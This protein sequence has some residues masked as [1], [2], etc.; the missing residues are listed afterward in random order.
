VKKM[1]SLALTLIIVAAFMVPVVA[2]AQTYQSGGAPPTAPISQPLV[3]E[4]TIAVKMVE[5]FKLGA[6]TDEVEAENL[7]V[8]AGIAPRN[9]WIADY[10]VTP[11]IA[12]EL[13][14]AVSDAADSG[15]LAM[16]K[17][18]AVLAFD[19]ILSE[20]NLAVKPDTSGQAAEEQAAAYPDN[21]VIDDYYYDEGPPVV[22]Y[23]APPPYYAHLYSWVPYPFWWWNFSFPGFFVL[24]DFHRP[25]FFHNRLV[26]VSNHFFDHRTRRFV[27]FD[28]RNRFNDRLFVDRGR[29]IREVNRTDIRVV[30]PT[31]VRRGAERVF[32]T[33][34]GRG[35]SGGETRRL[36]VDRTRGG[37]G[38]DNRRIDVD[39]SRGRSSGGG[40]RRFDIDRGRGR[41][42]G[43]NRSFDVDRTRGGSDREVRSGGRGGRTDNRAFAPSSANVRTVGPSRRDGSF[44]S[45]SGR[46]GNVSR[47]VERRFSPLSDRSGSSSRG[48]SFTRQMD[49]SPRV[50]TP[51][52]SSSSGGTR[53]FS[54][55]SGGDRMFRSSGSRGS[56]PSF[57]SGRGSSGGGRSRR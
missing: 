39:R 22:T 57:G 51:S 9:G 36:D 31:E 27:R 34:R 1:K 12:N 5:V 23:Y 56:S 35:R 2:T 52:R 19:G 20:Y 53:L 29:K 24:V 54:A 44:V 3:R 50:S 49:R 10:P 30:G 40:D 8:S 11:D 25:F 6:T 16:K 37:S 17:E 28:H 32:N 46:D 41:S 14:E 7:L 47:A 18:E 33:D 4:G 43:D 42:G 38:G 26:L 15:T 48:S 55:P 21:T 45:P 13:R